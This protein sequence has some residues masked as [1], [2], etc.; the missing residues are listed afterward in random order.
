MQVEANLNQEI[1]RLKGQ[2]AASMKREQDSLTESTQVQMWSIT[3]TY[4]PVGSARCWTNWSC[5][6]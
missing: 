6:N 4:L 2:L 5:S 3:S 1:D